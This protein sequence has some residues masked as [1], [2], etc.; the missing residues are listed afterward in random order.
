MDG[1]IYSKRNFPSTMHLLYRACSCDWRPAS[2]T[3]LSWCS[4]SHPFTRDLHNEAISVAKIS[5]LTRP[6]PPSCYQVQQEDTGLQ[7][8]NSPCKSPGLTLK[9]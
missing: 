9:L 7:N 8:I 6:E 2:I 4:L 3:L 5:L 1:A